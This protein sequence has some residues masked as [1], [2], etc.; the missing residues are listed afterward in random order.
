[1]WTIG[2]DVHQRSSSLCILDENGKTVKQM[3]VRGGWD[4]LIEVLKGVDQPFSI[5]YEA[6]C[7]Y[8]CLHDKLAGIAERVVVAHPGR[9]RLIFRSK[10]KNDRADAKKLATL[11]FLDQVPT[12]Y[13]PSIEVRDWRGLIEFRHRLVRKRICVKNGLR[14]LFRGYG[15]DLPSGKRL[16][17]KKGGKELQEK[18]LPTQRAA[19]QRDLLLDELEHAQSRIDRVEAELDRIAAEHPGVYLL[20]T[21]PGVGP[22]TAEAVMAYID[23]AARFTRNKKVGSYFGLVPCQDQSADRNRL[24]HI[25]RQGP[26]TV[27]KLIT[28][29]A[30]QG[31]RRSAHLREYFERIQGGDRQRKKIALVATAHHLLRVMHSMLGSGETWRYD[32][33]TLNKRAA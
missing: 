12:V 13:V 28:E 17:T 3:K 22:R 23:D 7:G 27:R 24:G 25:T 5:L 16:W 30:W 20:R 6:S 19:L 26:S 31:I 11:L 10:Q 33:E 9:L 21:I 8:G 4:S 14:S 1:M 2:L 18:E 29:A 15:I 32:K